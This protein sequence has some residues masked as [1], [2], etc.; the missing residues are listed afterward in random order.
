MTPVP[1]S[2]S[3]GIPSACL[4]A[5]ILAY[6]PVNDLVCGT[7]T[8]VPPG[9]AIAVVSMSHVTCVLCSEEGGE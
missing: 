4:G 5:S 1:L 3:S 7:P 2:L 6:V 9:A 8:S